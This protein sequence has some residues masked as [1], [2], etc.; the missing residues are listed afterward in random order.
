[1][2]PIVVFVIFTM[3]ISSVFVAHFAKERRSVI[4]SLVG[5]VCENWDPPVRAPTCDSSRVLRTALRDEN[6]RVAIQSP[7]SIA[8]KLTKL[9]DGSPF[10]FFRG[11]AAFF[12]ANLFCYGNEVLISKDAGMIP[13]VVSNGDCHPEN[14][15]LME[16]INHDN[17][18]W[19]VNDFDQSFHAPFS[20][21]GVEG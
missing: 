6:C 18:L 20:S 8:A 12:Y 13:Q 11:T 16:G 4:Q 19:G 7:S 10:V 2:F 21:D 17:L 1:M 14:F 5:P 3:L 9:A 15:G